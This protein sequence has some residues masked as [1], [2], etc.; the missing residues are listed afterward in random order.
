MPFL[1]YVVT[2]NARAGM[3]LLTA[4]T[5]VKAPIQKPPAFLFPHVNM[6]IRLNSDYLKASPTAARF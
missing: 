4:K 3:T 6:L 2:L 1:H 5:S